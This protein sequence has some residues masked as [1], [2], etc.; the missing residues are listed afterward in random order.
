MKKMNKVIAATMIMAITA[1]M[2]AMA[3]NKKN[4]GND[5][6]AKVMVVMNDMDKRDTHHYRHHGY[7]HHPEMRVCAFKV[8][9]HSAP[10]HMVARPERIH[11]VIDAHWNPRTH[12]VVV[13]YDARRTT[14]HHIRHTMESRHHNG[15]FS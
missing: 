9:R 6:K 10:S 8:N 14:A 5:N 3:G 13:R 15:H 1:A 4:F 12:E 2:P 11:G 7:A